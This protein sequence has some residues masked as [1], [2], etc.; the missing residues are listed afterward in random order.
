VSGLGGYVRLT[1]PERREAVAELAELTDEGL[2]QRQIAAVL[3]VDHKTVDRD[4]AGENSPGREQNRHVDAEPPGAAGANTPVDDSG[5]P[6][7]EDRR[8]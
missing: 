4:M 2:S 3:G 6:E 8:P 5:E 1:L 7:P